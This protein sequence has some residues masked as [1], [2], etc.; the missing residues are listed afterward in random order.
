MEAPLAKLLELLSAGQL[1]VREPVAKSLLDRIRRGVS[2]S[3]DIK[4]KYI[5]LMLDQG[6][7]D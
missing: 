7:L 2:L 3:R 4:Q 5:D 6:L 1:R